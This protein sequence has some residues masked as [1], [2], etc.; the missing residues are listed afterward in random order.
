MGRIH[1]TD[2]SE[3]VVGALWFS[4]FFNFH[5]T[6]LFGVEDVATLQAFDIFSVVM[7]GNNAYLGMLTDSCHQFGVV[8]LTALSA[9]L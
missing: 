7:P 3:V 6:E 4:G 1:D 9:R 8:G 5:V 2:Y